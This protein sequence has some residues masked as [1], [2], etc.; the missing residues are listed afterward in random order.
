VTVGPAVDGEG[1][2]EE[3]DGDGDGATVA[4]GTLVAAGTAEA[5]GAGAWLDAA[6]AA[7]EA[8]GP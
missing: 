3:G 7:D 2:A 1:P 6:L 8:I 5:D 4:E